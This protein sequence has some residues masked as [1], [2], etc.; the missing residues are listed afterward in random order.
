MFRFMPRSTAATRRTG[1]CA[2]DAGPTSSAASYRSAVLTVRARSAPA[3]PGVSRT[4]ATSE[5]GSRSTVET[6]A[7]IAP[8]SRTI[9]VS[10][11]V[12]RPSIPT[13]PD[14]ASRSCRVPSARQLL[15]RREASRTTNP[16]TCTPHDSSSS[17]AMP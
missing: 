15:A 12:S 5:P 2:V 4:R 11:R 10:A 14:D 7:R 16:D 3:I 1:P 6:A 9:K 13:I 8:C 17:G